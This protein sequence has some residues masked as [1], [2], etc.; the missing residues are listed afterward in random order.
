MIEKTQCKNCGSIYELIWN[1]DD[2]SW[3]DEFDY[4]ED[5]AG[6]TQEVIEVDDPCYCPFCGIH[7]DYDE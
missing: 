4:E 5:S 6:M 1:D 2:E 7:Q 3:R